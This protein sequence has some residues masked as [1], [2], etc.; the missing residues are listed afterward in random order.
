MQA[1]LGLKQDGAG[2]RGKH[3]NDNGFELLK[4]LDR[5]G[6]NDAARIRDGF[7]PLSLAGGQ[8]HS[9]PPFPRSNYARRCRMHSSISFTALFHHLDDAKAPR[10]CMARTLPYEKKGRSLGPPLFLLSIICRSRIRT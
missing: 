4:L 1:I 10:I 9:N 2:M 3:A 8:P 7:E 6:A 5:K